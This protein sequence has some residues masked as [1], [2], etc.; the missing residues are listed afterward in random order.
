M[1]QVFFQ[2]YGFTITDYYDSSDVVICENFKITTNEDILS[3]GISDGGTNS[4]VCGDDKHIVD[5]TGLYARL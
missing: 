1:T 5:Y 2:V 3:F 4:F